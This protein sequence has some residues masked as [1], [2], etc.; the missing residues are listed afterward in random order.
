MN[1]I[2]LAVHPA[3]AHTGIVVAVAG[4]LRHSA[5]VTRSL[6]FDWY[7]HDVFDTVQR[8]KDVARC[9]ALQ[10]TSAHTPLVAIPDLPDSRGEVDLHVLLERA[11]LVGAVAGHWLV[12][13]IPPATIRR[14]AG[15]YPPKIHGPGNHP[16]RRA[17]DVAAAALATVEAVA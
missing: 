3:W 8:A 16:L 7:L 10:T 17:W 11:Q 5:I 4:Q 12:T 14:G 2:V 13:R 1:R 9:I 6:P 15:S